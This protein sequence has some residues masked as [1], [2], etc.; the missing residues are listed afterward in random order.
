MTPYAGVR[1][2][3]IDTEA[4]K[5][6]M[7]SFDSDPQYIFRFPIGVKVGHLF[8][9]SGFTLRPQANLS[10][11]PVLG[12]TKVSTK[13]HSRAIGTSETS[14]ARMTDG[15]YYDASVGVTAGFYGIALTLAY[16]FHGSEHETEHGVS[17]TYNWRF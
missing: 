9:C 5:I 13:I 3:F 6:G 2:A 12:D 10:I 17:L 1:H 4:Y 11:E 8:N 15:F 7:V 16:D 14:K